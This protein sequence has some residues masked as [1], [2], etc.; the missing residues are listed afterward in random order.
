MNLLNIYPRKLRE[1]YKKNIINSGIKLPPEKYH[2]KITIISLII[3]ILFGTIFSFMKVNLFYCLGVLIATNIFFY[4]KISLKASNRIKKME[5]VFP[6]VLLLMASNLR[7]GITIDRAF[8]LSA[9]PEFDPLDKEILKTG[10]EIATGK[11]VLEALRIMSKK[12]GSEK[13]SKVVSLIISGLRGGGKISNLLEETARNMKQKEILERKT[14]SSILMYVIF[15]FFAVGIGAPLLFGLGTVLVDVIISLT[16]RLPDMSASQMNMPLTFSEVSISPRFILFFS[17]AFM[18]IT[19]LISSLIMGLV[20][21]GEGKE[22]LKYFIPLM[23]ISLTI[24]FIIR[25]FLSKVLL[26]VINNV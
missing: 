2:N 19:N 14:A 25:M 24:F 13:I 12:I 3:T 26:D 1:V 9:R 16:S 6:D 21:K 17:I 5:K 8:L 22:G 15:I 4:F 20:N 18:T 23:G 7:S 10:K 11:E